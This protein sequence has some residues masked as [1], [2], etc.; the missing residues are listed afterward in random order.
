MYK[1]LI[2][3]ILSLFTVTTLQAQVVGGSLEKLAK[4]F[5][6]GKY[7]KCLDKAEGY[8]F[9]EKTKREPEP[10]LYMSMC[11]LELS[12]SDDPYITDYYKN[13]VKSAI[14]FA[15]KF[16]QKDKKDHLYSKNIKYKT[17]K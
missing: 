14:K 10:Y 17:H 5:N 8:T 4:Y 6:Q 16:K 7:E 9:N 1:A 11:F 12:K 3:T 15:A 2:F 13:P